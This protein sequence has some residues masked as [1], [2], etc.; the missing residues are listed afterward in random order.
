LYATIGGT[1]V[2][3]DAG[4][5]VSYRIEE[6]PFTTCVR[7]LGVDYSPVPYV[8]QWANWPSGGAST[9]STAWLAP[10]DDPQHLRQVVQSQVT[11]E[12]AVAA[13]QLAANQHYQ[14]LDA[15]D[16]AAWDK[17]LSSCSEGG[18]YADAWHPAPYLGLISNFHATLND[19]DAEVAKDAGSYQA[20]MAGHGYSVA[21]YSDLVAYLEDQLPVDTDIPSIGQAGGAA[22]DAWTSLESDAYAADATCRSTLYEEGMALLAPVLQQFEADNAQALVDE[23]NGWDSLVAEARQPDGVRAN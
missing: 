1:P 7:A 22:W 6:D 9:F 13:D 15:T 2:E 3:R 10:L 4:G 23:Q 8:E 21:S 20:C 16:R 14:A 17:A 11:A 12:R 18:G 19:V 5:L